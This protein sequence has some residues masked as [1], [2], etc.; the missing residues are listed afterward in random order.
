MFDYNSWDKKDDKNLTLMMGNHMTGVEG[1]YKPYLNDWNPTARIEDWEKQR[2]PIPND[3]NP[4]A[5]A[6]Y[7]NL[8][9]VYKVHLSDWHLLARVEEWEK[10]VSMIETQQLVLI[11]ETSSQYIKS[12]SVIDIY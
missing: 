8:I 7:R 3:R 9:S 1:Q 4:T 5:G 12:I 6:D 2:I 11:I 10:P